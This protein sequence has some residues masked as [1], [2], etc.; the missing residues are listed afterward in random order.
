MKHPSS[1]LISV[2]LF[3]VIASFFSGGIRI[4]NITKLLIFKVN[5]CICLTGNG[6]GV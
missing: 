6:N 5:N 1:S 2:Q 4:I 3:K